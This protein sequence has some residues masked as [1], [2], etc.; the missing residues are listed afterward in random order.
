MYNVYIYIYYIYYIFL[1][2]HII[3]KMIE[4]I[5]N[6]S[7]CCQPGIVEVHQHDV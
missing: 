3:H 6:A 7:N 1:Y 2:M 5:I 4:I